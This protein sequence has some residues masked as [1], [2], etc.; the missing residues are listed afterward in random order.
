MSER[1]YAILGAWIFGIFLWIVYQVC[2]AIKHHKKINA[3]CKK[4]ESEKYMP[5]PPK[6]DET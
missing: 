2:R 3:I 1:D 4:Y 5:E 6:E